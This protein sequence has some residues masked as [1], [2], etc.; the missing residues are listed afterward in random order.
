LN[1]SLLGFF[2][3]SR[4]PN[5]ILLPVLIRFRCILV[6]RLTTRSFQHPLIIA[7]LS[8]QSKSFLSHISCHFQQ[9]PPQL[10]ISLFKPPYRT[11]PLAYTLALLQPRHHLP[12]S[13]QSAHSLAN[14][15]RTTISSSFRPLLSQKPSFSRTTL[16]FT[17]SSQ[18]I[19]AHST[20][21]ISLSNLNTTY[22]Y[23]PHYPKLTHRPLLIRQSSPSSPKTASTNPISLPNRHFSNTPHTS[24]FHPQSQNSPHRT[25]RLTPKSHP[26]RPTSRTFFYTP[27]EPNPEFSVKPLPPAQQFTTPYLKFAR[28]GDEVLVDYTIYIPNGSI[29]DS[30]TRRGKPSKLFVGQ[31]YHLIVGFDR[32]LQLTPIGQKAKVTIPWDLAYGERGIPGTVPPY[33]TVY[34]ELE[35]LQIRGKTRDQYSMLKA[36]YA[37][38]NQL[39][40]T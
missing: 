26:Q 23:L 28:P 15:L 25:P 20:S 38:P 33:S 13:M 4:S 7:P 29:I 19:T 18:H 27:T 11:L 34:I 37:T 22:S 8:I 10:P 2:F 36:P 31:E 12:I 5:R 3:I 1:L 9:P 39:S 17:Q 16:P 32:A 6:H 35:L 30:T 40:K 14:P 21:A 24:P